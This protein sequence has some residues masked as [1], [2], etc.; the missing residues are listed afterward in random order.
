[1]KH[2]KEFWFAYILVLVV[3]VTIVV[4]V[5]SIEKP[6]ELVFA[7]KTPEEWMAP[8]LYLDNQL[9]GEEREL[10]IY[11][12]DLIANTAHYFGPN[13]IIK[14]ITNGMNCQNCHLDAGTR[15][16]GNNYGAVAS[17]Y[18]KFRDRSGSVESIA[19]R[20]NDC[21]ER[22]L[23]GSALDTNSR[24]MKAMVTYIK[25]LGK[26]VKKGEK[27]LGSGIRELTY[28]DRAASPQKGKEAYAVKCV[29][30]H[31]GNGEGLKTPDGNAYAYPP[32]W[33]EHS[34]NNGAGL[35]RLSRFA[36]YIRDNMPFNQSTHQS[37]ALTNEEAWDVAAY[38]NS[39]PRPAKDLSEDWPDISKKPI[40]HPFGPFTDG[41]SEQQHK[42]GP[43]QPIID[44]RNKQV[45]EKESKKLLGVK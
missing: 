35:F 38:V 32:L 15:A 6:R 12:E 17:T 28:L 1:M 20:V 4:K 30:C 8:S 29:S 22:S 36:G 2:L 45:N 19:R 21:F 18:P 33:G 14:P 23:N 42:F 44:A 43:Y 7:S 13:G 11:G 37:P 5:A 16:W 34:Y 26:D 39:Q 10:V 40:D 27:P 25:W 31:G 41:F 24:E 3:L 9:K